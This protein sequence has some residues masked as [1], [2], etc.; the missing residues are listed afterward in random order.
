[1]LCGPQVAA[2]MRDPARARARSQ[3][4]RAQAPRPLC[5]P[6]NLVRLCLPCQGFNARSTCCI[7]IC[8]CTT[9]WVS[10]LGQTFCSQEHAWM[11]GRTCVDDQIAGR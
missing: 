3:L 9:H 10:M 6:A 8:A 7:S 1:M 2:L 11:R 5:L 4:P